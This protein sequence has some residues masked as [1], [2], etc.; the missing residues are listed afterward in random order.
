V[1]ARGVEAVELE[2][3]SMTQELA[4]IALAF[5]KECL[6]WD[7]VKLAPWS[8][9]SMHGYDLKAGFG[10]TLAFTDLNAVMEEVRGWLSSRKLRGYLSIHH[11]YCFAVHHRTP[12][13]EIEMSS[14]I[15]IACEDN[16]CHA[17]LAACVEANRKM[18]G[19]AA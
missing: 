2:S 8:S 10:C 6:G 12:A 5:A 3:G 17:L 19:E 1:G 16:P 15:A 7:E 13:G 4:D 9:E 18:K 11:G 14:Q